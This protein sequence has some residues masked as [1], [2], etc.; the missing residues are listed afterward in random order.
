MANEKIRIVSLGGLD[1]DGK[2]CIVVEIND[3]IFVVG[4]GIKNPDKTM[5]GIDYI[6]PNF[7]YLKANKERIKGYFLLHGHDDENGALA[8]IYEDA[9]APIYASKTT[10]ALFKMFTKHVKKDKVDYKFRE[11]EATS[12]F[13]V[14]SR[15]ISFF[16]TSHNVAHSSGIAISTQYGNIVITGDFVVENNA[17]PAYLHDTNAIAKIAERGTL[18]LLSESIYATKPGYTAPKYRV[19]PHIQEPIKEAEG[20]TYVAMFANNFYNINEL[21]RIALQTHKKVVPYDEETAEIIQNMIPISETPWPRDFFAP[22]SDI[23]RIREQDTVVLMLAH[24]GRLYNK[25]AILAAGQADNRCNLK[26]TDTFIVCCPPNDNHEIEAVDALDELY[27]SGCRVLNVTRKNFS[28]MHASEEDLKTMIALL[29]P[30]YYIPVKGLYK[31]L[32]ANATVAV[33]MGV[34]LSH[35]NIFLLENG[36]S[37]LIDDKGARM[38]NENIPHG[39]IM[40]DGIGVGDI[41]EQ[42]IQDREKLAQGVIIISAVISKSKRAVIAG[43]DIQVRGLVYLKDSEM[44]VRDVTRI[45]NATADEALSSVVFDIRKLKDDVYDKVSRAVR[46][47]TGKEPMVLPL[48]LEND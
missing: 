42:V 23:I 11:V 47:Q 20:R 12:D 45:F 41:S 10:I 43:P 2:N 3:D 18:C 21:L 31:D 39:D 13:R 44:I 1:E 48:L 33:N 22:V 35:R 6:I 29:K 16:H 19:T 25:M 37:L 14:A 24:G 4:A 38:F 17:T 26:P 30:Q 32:L 34:H 46:R 36:M 5:P 28:R 7:D 27:R 15:L 8:Y 40:I 9:P